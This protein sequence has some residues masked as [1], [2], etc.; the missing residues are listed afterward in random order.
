[1]SLR[2]ALKSTASHLA[3]D[4]IST[5]AWS[6]DGHA[7]AVGWTNGFS[8]WSAYGR[9]ILWGVNGDIGSG[10]NDSEGMARPLDF[11]DYYAAGVKRALWA[12]GDFELWLL[13]PTRPE[14]KEMG[15]S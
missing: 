13:C 8:I 9:L 3:T 5:L 12:H 15:T 7:L 11:Q 4:Q 10:S 2:D 1:M 6:S 14:P